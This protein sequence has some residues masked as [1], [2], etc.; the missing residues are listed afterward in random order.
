MSR[1]E[2]SF[3]QFSVVNGSF[4]RR[5][6]ILQCHYQ[7]DRLFPFPLTPP[8]PLSPLSLSLSLSPSFNLSIYL[9]IYLSVRFL[10]PS[11]FLVPSPPIFPKCS[12]NRWPLVCVET[13]ETGRCLLRSGSRIDESTFR[14]FGRAKPLSTRWWRATDNDREKPLWLSLFFFASSLFLLLLLVSSPPPPPPSPPPPPPPSS[15]P[16]SSATS[17]SSSS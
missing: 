11:P 1:A 12:R 9:S 7:R 5:N 13:G 3:A 10:L 4:A 14:G 15:S 8:H 6:E 16:S 17:T 2:C